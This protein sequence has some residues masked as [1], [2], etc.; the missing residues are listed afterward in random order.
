[1]LDTSLKIYAR[2]V[3][4]KSQPSKGQRT[5]AHSHYTPSQMGTPKPC[6]VSK[7]FA[8]LLRRVA[9]VLSNYVQYPFHN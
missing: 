1:M 7:T 6:R 2:T 5:Q 4:T 9:T 8:L 3:L